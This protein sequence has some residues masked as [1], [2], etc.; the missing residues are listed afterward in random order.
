MKNNIKQNKQI[1]LLAKKAVKFADI[2]CTD[3]SNNNNKILNVNNGS[4]YSRQTSYL[5]EKYYM[6][7]TYEK[8]VLDTKIDNQKN[9]GI[10]LGKL[11]TI[12]LNGFK[13]N[14]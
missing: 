8:G 12:K 3:V 2:G 13:N 6:I 4:N 1:Q 14:D 7:K 10:G 9:A 11:L 5:Y